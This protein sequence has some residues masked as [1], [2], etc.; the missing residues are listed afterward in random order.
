MEKEARFHI[1][2]PY[3]CPQRRGGRGLGDSSFS[4]LP[5]GLL[6]D[7]VSCLPSLNPGSPPPTHLKHLLWGSLCAHRSG[8]GT[9]KE[10]NEDRFYSS[11]TCTPVSY[12]ALLDNGQGSIHGEYTNRIQSGNRDGPFEKSYW[13]VT[14]MR[15]VECC[16]LPQS[17]QNSESQ[18]F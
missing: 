13:L 16:R 11:H 15:L 3:T 8:Q 12:Q 18:H 10:G 1:I 5:Q 14:F 17:N 4:W 2:A 7:H 6:S 9:H